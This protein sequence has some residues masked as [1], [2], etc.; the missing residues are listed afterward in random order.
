MSAFYAFVT[1]IIMSFTQ[2]G[3]VPHSTLEK[4]IESNNSKQ[5]VA[6]S[7]DKVMVDILGTEGVYGHAQAELV[8]KG[9]FSKHPKGT[10]DYTYEG[11][12]TKDGAFAIGTYKTGG[13]S[14]R[15]TIHYLKIGA[16]FKVESI[17]VE[18]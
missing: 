1:A 16:G 7:K 5:I 8:L 17:A 12:P 18:K 2:V 15:I 14:Y 4:A 13:N 11:S 3:E 9:F 10:F 6:L